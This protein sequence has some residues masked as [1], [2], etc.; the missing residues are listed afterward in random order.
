MDGRGGLNMGK[1]KSNRR[2]M[3]FSQMVFVAIAVIVILS[4]VLTLVAR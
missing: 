4:F 3:S 2:R 1:K